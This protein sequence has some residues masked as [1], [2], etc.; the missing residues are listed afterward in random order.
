[1]AIVGLTRESLIRRNVELAL[2]RIDDD[3]FGSCLHCEQEISRR[4]SAMDA[5]L[6]SLPGSRRSWRRECPRRNRAYASR[7]GLAY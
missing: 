4:G 7:C 6:R 2:L 1:M 3:T 5:I